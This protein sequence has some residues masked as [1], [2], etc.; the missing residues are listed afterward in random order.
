MDDSGTFS[1]LNEPEFRW[2]WLSTLFTYAAAQMDAVI[3]GFLIYQM[4]GSSVNLGL[5][6]VAAG[7]PQIIGSIY[8]GI[9]ADRV[10]RMKLLLVTQACAI[11]FA[12][13][14]T[15]LLATSVIQFWHFIVLAALGG[16]TFAFVAP[17][18][19]SIVAKL[20]RPENLM[21][22]VALTSA[23]FNIMGILGPASVGLLL[24]VMPP[25]QAYLIIV[26]CFLA[27][28]VMLAFIRIPRENDMA[29]GPFH[30]E[31]TEGFRFIRGN[32]P[33]LGFLLVALVSSFFV[34]PNSFL[35]PALASAVLKV[36]QVGFGFICAARGV[37]ALAGSLVTA[38]LTRAKNK[39]TLVLVFLAVYGIFVALSALF[40]SY[41]IALLMVLCAGL[42]G[43]IY[44]ILCNTIILTSTPANMHGRVISIYTMAIGLTPVGALPMGAAADGIG[45]PVTFL[46]AGLI[47]VVFA[48]YMWF[49]IPAMRK[50]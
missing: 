6:T 15:A 37:G 20:V 9:L 25:Y 3:K 45:L 41:T 11:S 14:M 42:T 19:Q 24:T 50:L 2:Y 36:D 22:A 16:T 47:A 31:L 1:A 35:M 48:V 28:A 23:S 21:S 12:A 13:T 32:R 7:V 46:F 5:V 38:S 8:G 4:T 44:I 29:A 18:R 43:T 39:G 30:L 33:I 17:L 49:A 26:F 40:Q 10:D 34:V 27:G